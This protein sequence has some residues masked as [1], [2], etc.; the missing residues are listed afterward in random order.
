MA[1]L[2]LRQLPSALEKTLPGAMMWQRQA[3]G[4]PE[5]LPQRRPAQGLTAPSPDVFRRTS[6]DRDNGLL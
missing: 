5:R 6:G 2:L 3:R 4:R 1:G